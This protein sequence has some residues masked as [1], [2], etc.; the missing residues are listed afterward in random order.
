MRL[1]FADH[2]QI[3]ANIVQKILTQS[4]MQGYIFI[5]LKNL[6]LKCGFSGIETIEIADE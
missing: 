5:I 6:D 1:S 2:Y 4:S 3:K